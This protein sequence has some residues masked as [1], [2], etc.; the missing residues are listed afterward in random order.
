MNLNQLRRLGKNCIIFDGILAT[1]WI[2]YFFSQIHR[3]RMGDILKIPFSDFV[4]MGAFSL[5]LFYFKIPKGI[6]KLALCYEFLGAVIYV[7]LAIIAFQTDGK[8]LLYLVSI[9]TAT[10]ANLVFLT[11]CLRLTPPASKRL[12]IYKSKSADMSSAAEP[13]VL[14]ELDVDTTPQDP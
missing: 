9:F 5:S 10:I 3:I 7:A 14:S 13:V 1:L 4:Q 12:I 11:F 2:T 6:V 8:N